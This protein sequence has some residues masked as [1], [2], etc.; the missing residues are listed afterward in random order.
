MLAPLCAHGARVAPTRLG[1]TRLA[2]LAPEG[3]RA[4]R[5]MSDA[6]V[7][8]QACD[9]AQDVRTLGLCV[10]RVQIDG[11]ELALQGDLGP[12]WHDAEFE[13]GAFAHRWTDGAAQLPPGARLI[14]VDLAGQGWYWRAPAER[15]TARRR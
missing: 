14:V 10:S 15:L 11:A 3:A 2:F 6:F 4:L 8:A 9:E 12:G 13:A 7:P 5:L 1:D